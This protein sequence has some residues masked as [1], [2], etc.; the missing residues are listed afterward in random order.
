MDAK[1]I[2]YSPFP[3][4]FKNNVLW[5]GDVQ[6]RNE[7][8]LKIELTRPRVDT[9]QEV[10]ENALKNRTVTYQ[11]QRIEMSFY[12]LVRNC[13]V[14][15]YSRIGLNDIVQLYIYDTGET[16]TLTNVRFADTGEEG[17][18]V[19]SVSFTFDAESVTAQNC[20]QSNYTIAPC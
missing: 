7:I 4:V 12:A 5:S 8:F 11:R 10:N 14:D 17:D 1:L 9:F 18:A 15:F 13:L 20:E 6:Y 16:F 19:N 3:V 2:S